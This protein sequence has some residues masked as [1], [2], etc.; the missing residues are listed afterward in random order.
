MIHCLALI[1][2]SFLLLLLR[3]HQ[4]TC[5]LWFLPTA[6][7]FY[8]SAFFGR[9]WLGHSFRYHSSE[10]FSSSVAQRCCAGRSTGSSAA[11]LCFS[12][13][14]TPSVQSIGVPFQLWENG[15]IRSLVALLRNT[16]ENS[17]QVHGQE[18]SGAAGTHVPLRWGHLERPS[19]SFSKLSHWVY[20]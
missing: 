3:T 5:L 4:D 17:C 7:V 9:A 1:R 14:V 13:S 18:S 15:L 10:A 6:R 12:W 20:P 2:S 19:V 11:T 8:Q 16:M